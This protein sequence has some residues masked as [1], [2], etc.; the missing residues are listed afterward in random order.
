MEIIGGMKVK[1]NLKP[2]LG[3]E[4]KNSMNKVRLISGKKISGSDKIA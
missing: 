2:P 1:F 4:H 3:K